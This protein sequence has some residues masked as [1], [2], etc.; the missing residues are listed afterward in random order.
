MLIFFVPLADI[1]GAKNGQKVVIEM[2]ESN[3]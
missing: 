3:Q 1:N 2:T